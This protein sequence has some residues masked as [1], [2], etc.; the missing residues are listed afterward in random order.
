MNIDKLIRGNK[1]FR[2]EYV[3]GARDFLERLASQGQSPG[4]LFIGCSD[5]R[6]VP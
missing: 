5:S 1:S 2:K 6:V 3:A 4:A